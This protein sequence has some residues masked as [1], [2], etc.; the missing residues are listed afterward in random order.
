[1]K[2]INNQNIFIENDYGALPF[3][4][5]KFYE[6]ILKTAKYFLSQ[7]D[8]LNNSCL[9]IDEEINTVTFDIVLCSD[10]KIHEINREYRKKDRPTDVITFALFADSEEDERF[11]FDEEVN[12]GEILVSVDTVKRQAE[13]NKNTFYDELLVVTSHGIL[14]LLGFDHMTQEDYDFMVEKQNLYKVAT[15]V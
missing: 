2:I 5:V 13:E 12:L 8:I 14:H 4:E 6:D 10:E 9:N 7:E 15:D 1:M 11:I 3:D